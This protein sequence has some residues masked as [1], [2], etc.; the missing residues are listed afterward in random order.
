MIRTART[1]PFASLF[2][3]A[4]L[5]APSAAGAHTRGFLSLGVGLGVP[6]G[7]VGPSYYVPGYYTTQVQP[8]VVTPGHYEARTETVLAAPAHYETRVVPAVERTTYDKY[9]WPQTVAVQPART[10]QVLVPDR[11]ETR[12][13]QVYIPPVVANQPVQV[14]VPGYWA[15]GY[16]G[17]ASVFVGGAF[18]R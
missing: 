12:T 3:A 1:I 8:V 16:Y 15:G 10:E 7:T 9:G 4:A 2:L 14:Y 6:I 11:F 5:V 17:G 18:R 13:T